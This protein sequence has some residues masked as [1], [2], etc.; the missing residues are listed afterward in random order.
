MSFLDLFFVNLLLTQVIRRVSKY[1]PIDNIMVSASSNLISRPGFWDDYPKAS[2]DFCEPNY[3][4]SFYVAEVF[5]SGSSL[6]IAYLGVI[7]LYR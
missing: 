1:L 4:S 5:N 2:I 7:G 6:V 3:V